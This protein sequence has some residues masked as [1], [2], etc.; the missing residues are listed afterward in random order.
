MWPSRTTAASNANS[1]IVYSLWIIILSR[2]KTKKRLKIK[3][4]YLWSKWKKNYDKLEN[5]ETSQSTVSQR[6]KFNGSI[7][8]WLISTMRRKSGS[9]LVWRYIFEIGKLTYFDPNY[10]WLADD[11]VVIVAGN[12]FSPERMSLLSFLL[13]FPWIIIFFPSKTFQR[14]KAVSFVWT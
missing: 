2:L 3:K 12:E 6:V 1:S 10:L 7:S 8:N 4:L 5:N 11:F 9:H 13:F 14:D